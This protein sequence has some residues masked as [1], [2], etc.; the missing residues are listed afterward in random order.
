MRAN[1]KSAYRTLC[2]RFGT[3]GRLYAAK[4]SLFWDAARRDLI[5]TPDTDQLFAAADATLDALDPAER[6]NLRE[7][8]RLSRHDVAVLKALMMEKAREVA[9]AQAAW[10]AVQKQRGGHMRAYDA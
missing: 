4:I 2:D 10:I 1:D 6:A 5:A 9:K 7:M 8:R 3:A